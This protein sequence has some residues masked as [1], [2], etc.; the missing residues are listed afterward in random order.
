LIAVNDLQS[1]RH[2]EVVAQGFLHAKD[3]RTRLTDYAVQTR[4]ADSMSDLDKN[5]TQVLGFAALVHEVQNR[6]ASIVMLS[7]ALAKDSR[8][9]DPI[10]LDECLQRIHRAA[11]EMHRIV[12]AVRRLEDDAP[13]ERLTVDLSLLSTRA[14]QRHVEQDPKFGRA[15]VIVQSHIQVS[16]DLEE[17]QILVD[18]LISNALKFSAARPSPQVHVTA[19]TE[20]DCT[21]V[22]VSDNGIGIAPED[23]ARI[24]EPFTRCHSGFEGAGVGLAIAHRIVGRHGGRIWAKGEPGLGTTVSFCIPSCGSGGSL[25]RAAAE[26]LVALACG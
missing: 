11:A 10:Y 1:S 20:A 16:G 4:P 26:P 19:T 6:V 18:N 14:I 25:V 15:R 8:R 21:I 12:N 23:A 5:S 24:F 17:I 7:R 13:L 2:E 9:H 22:H 3:A